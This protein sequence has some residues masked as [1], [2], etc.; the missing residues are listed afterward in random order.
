MLVDTD[1]GYNSRAGYAY[2]GMPLDA[3]HVI[4]HASRPDLSDKGFNLE[5]ENQY[6]NRGKAATEKMA[7][8]QGREATDQ[9][10]AAGLFK[11]HKN[12]LLEDVVLPGRKGSKERNDFMEPI[13]RKV[14]EY[15]AAQRF[16][17]DIFGDTVGGDSTRGTGERDLIINS[18][19]GNVTIGDNALRKNGKNGNGKH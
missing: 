17:G 3:G 6:A 2:G 13:N 12:K 4:G 9:E 15:L 18:G 7:A 8:N 14:E 1:R 10:L 11:S 16:A 19:G 5:L